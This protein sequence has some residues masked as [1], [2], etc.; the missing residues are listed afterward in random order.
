MKLK[1]LRQVLKMSKWTFIGITLQAYLCGM[2]F[3]NETTAQKSI[4]DIYLSIHIEQASIAEI[5]KEIE[6][7]TDFLFTYNKRILSN[8]GEHD[9]DF[10]E[11]SL[12]NVLSYVST[13]YH[14]NFKRIDSQIS[15]REQ[16]SDIKKNVEEVLL[17]PNQFL[18]NGSITSAD[19]GDPL[20]GVSILIV[21]TT[22][23][24]TSD[25]DGNYTLEVNQGAVLQFSYVG[26]LTEEVNVGNQSIIDVVLQLDQDQLEEVVVTALGIEREKKGLGYS[27]TDVGGDQIVQKSEPDV[28]R[29]L[30]SKVPGVNIVSA[31]GSVG[32]N[33]NITIRGNSSLTGNNQPLFVVDGVPFD[34][35]TLGGDFEN[36]NV[37]T[38]RAFDLDPNNIESMTVLKG[39]AASALYG[40][41]AANGVIV[42]TTKAGKKGTRKGLEVTYNTSYSLEEVA[43]LPDYQYEFGP[44]GG[45]IL[46]P[47]FFGSMGPRFSSLETISHPYNTSALAE[48]FPEY[49]G[50]EIPFES[51]RDQVRDFLRTGSV[52]ENSINIS[53]GNDVANITAGITRTK[54]EGFIPNSEV[55]RTSVNIGGNAT[56]NNGIFFNGTINYVNT[57]QKTPPIRPGILGGT[58]IMERVLLIPTHYPWMDL[59]YQNPL[60]GS[61]VYYRNGVDNPRWVTDNAFYQSNVD[62]FYGN[63]VAGYDIFD[64][65]TVSY[66]IGFNGYTDRRQD[67]VSK[68]SANAAFANGILVETN[69]F[70]E[71]L[72]GNL[73]ITIDKQLTDLL[74]L[75]ATVG[76]NVNQRTTEA[77]SVEATNQ[78]IFGIEDITNFDS[79]RPLSS[80][81]IRRRFHGVFADVQLSY[82]DIYFLNLVARNDWSS[83]LPTD[84]RSFFYPGVSASIIFTDALDIQSNVL[85]YGKLRASIAQVGNDAPPYRVFTQ[86]VTNPS[87]SGLQFPFTSANGQIYNT[88]SNDNLIGNLGLKPE[89][90]TEYEVGLDLKG[91]NNKVG[92]EFTF[93]NR[94]SENNIVQIDVAPSSGVRNVTENLG[95]VRNRGIEIGL[96][97]NPVSLSNGFNWNIFTAFTRNR[98]KVLSLEDGLSQ[99]FIGGLAGGNLGIV[100]RPGLPFGQLFG[101]R[102]AR[103]DEG[104]L[105]IR[106]NN[107]EPYQEPD[108]G[109]IGDPNPDFILGITNTFSYKGLTL[110]VLFDWKQGGDMFSETAQQLLGRGVT[111]ALDQGIPREAARIIPGFVGTEQEDGTIVPALDASGNKI[112]NNFVI[113]HY[114]LRRFADTAPFE[115]NVFDATTVRLR[116]ISLSY[117]FPSS[118]LDKTPFGSAR[119][120]VSGRNLWFNAPNFP[121]ELNFDP[122]TSAFGADSNAQGLD[123]MGVPST[124]R[125]GVNLSVTF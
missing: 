117:M 65:L 24:T 92:L 114:Q 107:G 43:S 95:E 93:Y 112:P 119:L 103:D 2:L 27:V 113:G 70:R 21:G 35:S 91:F 66:Q 121:E 76:H 94:V 3:A 29:A 109:I 25:L 102:Y 74:N 90:T 52:I 28:A 9:I 37:V 30:T 99:I 7:K 98:N 60:D 87:L 82:K 22:S 40:S 81:K 89:I 80:S 84:N 42:I 26:Y 56:L 73:L 62:R 47:G 118:L 50:V 86:F 48:A 4:K 124:K 83:T 49:Q 33:T 36:G 55:G 63:L 122:E 59:P 32:G 10:S 123:F 6:G 41:R 125:Y 45:Q 68:G 34:N 116:E 88:V 18:I 51:R 11:E 71:E 23:G 8:R 13:Q 77:T 39:A 120:S 31:G 111:T 54:N 1:F 69:L 79:F 106:P 110:S 105:L 85:E 53:T 115:G 57:D 72:D 16:K 17:T 108:L 58:S 15:I 78:I 67:F 101:T 19:N 20:P 46:V 97:L 5:L 14:L 12:M 100:H 44:G 96:N 38:N 61:S 75:R 104:N 64:W